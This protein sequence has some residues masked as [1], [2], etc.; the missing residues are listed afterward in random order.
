MKFTLPGQL[1][2]PECGAVM[3]AA[4]K[5]RKV[6]EPLFYEIDAKNID[7]VSI[8]LRVDGSLGSFGASGVENIEVSNNILSCDLVIKDHNWASIKE[9]EITQILKPL[10]INA[11][12]QCLSFSKITIN[13]KL[14]ENAL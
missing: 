6:I 7:E 14:F 12:I 13:E 3:R 1:K 8:I 10:I 9:H 2:G 5:I 4:I 11:I